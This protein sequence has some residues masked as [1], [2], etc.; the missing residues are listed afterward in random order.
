MVC[1]NLVSTHQGSVFL[2]ILSNYIF[3][4][5]TKVMSI[6][7]LI[8]CT[9]IALLIIA[10]LV[11]LFRCLVFFFCPV[12]GADPLRSECRGVFMFTVI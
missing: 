3:I 7:L 10:N 4:M 12:I 6:S 2:N 11:C 5:F 9:Y 8:L 1:K